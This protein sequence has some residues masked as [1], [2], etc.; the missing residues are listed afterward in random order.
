[1]IINDQLAGVWYEVIELFDLTQNSILSKA[2][3]RF[4]YK[5]N[6]SKYIKPIFF[7]D[8]KFLNEFLT[9]LVIR[10]MIINDQLAG[11]WSKVIELFDLTHNSILT[12]PT[13]RFKSKK[14]HRIFRS[15]RFEKSSSKRR[16]TPTK[17]VQ[18]CKRITCSSIYSTFIICLHI[19]R[20]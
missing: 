1:M 11:V 16:W 6:T 13:N 10:T 12:K 19:S 8:T 9:Y 14:T 5:K 15:E 18:R 2:T 7:A 3:N 17:K 4:K 20:V